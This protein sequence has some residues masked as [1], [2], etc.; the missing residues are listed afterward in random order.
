MF[1]NSFVSLFNYQDTQIWAGSNVGDIF[2]YNDRFEV[3]KVTTLNTIQILILNRFL[4]ATRNQL[5]TYVSGMD[6][7]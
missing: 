1:E 2:V 3:I 5:E 6:T 7:L 4:K